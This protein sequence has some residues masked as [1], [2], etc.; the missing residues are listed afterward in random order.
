VLQAEAA[1]EYRASLDADTRFA[2]LPELREQVATEQA[3]VASGGAADPSLTSVQLQVAAAQGAYDAALVTYQE[4]AARAQC[5]LDGTCGTGDA[6]TGTAYVQAQA[7]ADAQAAVVTTARASLDA[8][9]AGLGA[10]EARSATQAAADLETDEAELA[11]LTEDQTRLQQAFDETNADN[12]GILI[13]L[14]ALDRLS[15]RSATLWAAHVMLALLF[16]SIELLPVLMKL[17]L[18]FGP[19]SAYDR[20]AEL[21]DA[22]DLDVEELQQ[23]SR[24]E[25]AQ[26][27]EELLVLAERERIDRQKEQVLARRRAAVARQAALDRAAAAEPAVAPEAPAEPVGDDGW[28]PWDTSPAIRLARQAAGRTVRAV[29]RRPGDREPTTV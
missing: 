22:G 13:R 26:A 28:K 8:A 15:D 20:V 7:A 9:V 3:I 23:A 10:A 4:L 21:R 24:R 11:R 27:K 12:S 17:L 29:R 25:V 19:K 1:D 14:E 16:I 18:N 5:E 6:G 2:G